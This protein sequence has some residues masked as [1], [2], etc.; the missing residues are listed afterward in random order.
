MSDERVLEGIV[1]EFFLNTCRLRPQFSQPAVEAA[2]SCVH[3]VAIH[4]P[5]EAEADAIPL[6][7]GS[8][9]EFNIEPMLPHIGDVDV[10][11]HQSNP[12]SY[13]HLT[14]PTNREV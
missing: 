5:D 7:T 12:V 3:T 8:V 6:T 4:P 1:T 11:Y 9:A 10:M 14:L 13:T 2:M